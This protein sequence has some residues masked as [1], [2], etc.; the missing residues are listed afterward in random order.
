MTEI[1]GLTQPSFNKYGDLSIQVQEETGEVKTGGHYKAKGFA[2]D[3]PPGITSY[4]FSFP[5]PIAILAAEFNGSASN[6]GDVLDF[7]I[8]EDSIIG[9]ITSNVQVGDTVINA[10]AT[11]I[12]YAKVQ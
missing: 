4:E 2:H 12:Q 7:Y 3:Y 8:G 5:Y 10:D 11:T 6:A 1:L 9:T